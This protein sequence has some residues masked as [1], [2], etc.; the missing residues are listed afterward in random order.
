MKHNV[1]EMILLL[2]ILPSWYLC[3]LLFSACNY[4]YSFCHL[5]HRVCLCC[6]IRQWNMCTLCVLCFVPM[7][8]ACGLQM[9]IELI[10]D[11]TLE[12]KYCVF[13]L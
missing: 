6:C 2:L 9:E 10:V 1:L 4:H 8:I 13:S 7:V 3:E 11:H 12:L 5:V